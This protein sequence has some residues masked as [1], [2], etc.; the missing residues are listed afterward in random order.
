[1]EVLIHL[2][3]P[4]PESSEQVQTALAAAWTYQL[5]VESRIPQL[6]VLTHILDVACSLLYSLPAQSEHKQKAMEEA[7]KTSQ[8][9]TSSDTSDDIAIPIKTTENQT[10]LVSQ[11]TREVLGMSDDGKHILMMSF[12]NNNDTFALM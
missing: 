11:D 12:L 4:N 7:Y 5:D 6:L 3:S 9:S 1:M 8:W 2:S 10:K